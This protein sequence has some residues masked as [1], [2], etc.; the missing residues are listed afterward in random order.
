MLSY[1]RNGSGGKVLPKEIKEWL[2]VEKTGWTLEYIRSLKI[3]DYDTFSMF[4]E[5]SRNIEE[6]DKTVARKT[7]RMF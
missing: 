4:A 7:P 3:K 5:I 6:M 2:I 1:L